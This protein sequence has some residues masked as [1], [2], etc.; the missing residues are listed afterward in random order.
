MANVTKSIVV[1]GNVVDIY[2]LWTKFENFPN[3]M[4]H[5]RSVRVTGPDT[6]H[7]IMQGPMG[8]TLQWDAKTTSL[9]PGKEVAW[10]S[11]GGDIK[12][13]GKVLFSQAGPGKV[14]V[15]ATIDFDPPGGSLGR[16]LLEYFGDLDQ[17]VKEDLENFRNYAQSVL[18]AK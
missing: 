7:W 3:F 15:A 9:Q 18:V 13:S 11:T 5:I 1:D 6:T 10:E 14:Q 12:Q 8:V 17:R 16:K 2:T 4:R